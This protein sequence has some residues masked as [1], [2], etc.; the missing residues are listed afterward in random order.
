MTALTQTSLRDYIA[1]LAARQSTPGGGT[2]AAISAAQAAALLQMVANFTDD[3]DNKS[4]NN[5]SNNDAKPADI[6]SIIDKA[7]RAAEQFLILAEQDMTAFQEVMQAYRSRDEDRLQTALRM[8][9]EPPIKVIAGCVALLK[10]LR[11]IARIGNQN[12]ITDT[13]IAADLLASAL[14]SSELNV[15]IN[16]R[17]MKK[18]EVR[19]QLQDALRENGTTLNQLAEIVA[20]I[21]QSLAEPQAEVPRPDTSMPSSD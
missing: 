6:K 12:L 5:K 15:L 20:E 4:D 13:A 1:A 19:Q 14:R 18:P 7:S 21:K 11:L 8:A 3:I 16:L 10:D 2:V 9:A 17:Q